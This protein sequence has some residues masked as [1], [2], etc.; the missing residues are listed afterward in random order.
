MLPFKKEKK[1]NCQAFKGSFNNVIL[2]TLFV[3]F[4]NMYE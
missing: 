1:K 4:R 2:I 3:L